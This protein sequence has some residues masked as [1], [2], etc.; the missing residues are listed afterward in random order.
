MKPVEG[1]TI[2]TITNRCLTVRRKRQALTAIELLV[3]AA[4]SSLLIVAIL[5]L[6]RALHVQCRELMSTARSE[7]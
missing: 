6:T 1:N 5:G 2:R 7:P 3:A 4:L